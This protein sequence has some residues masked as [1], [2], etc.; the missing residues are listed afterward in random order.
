MR[1]LAKR[2]PR[3]ST[4]VAPSPLAFV[5]ACIAVAHAARE[6]DKAK[7]DVATLAGATLAGLEARRR[8]SAAVRALELAELRL[9]VIAC[10]LPDSALD[11]LASLAVGRG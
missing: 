5:D 10:E 6:L 9:R 3:A 4:Y 7:A 8:R 1:A 2:A 11:E